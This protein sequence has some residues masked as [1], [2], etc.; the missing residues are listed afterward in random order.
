MDRT[1]DEDTIPAM[2]LPALHVFSPY[3]IST[4]KH[5]AIFLMNYYRGYNR[6]DDRLISYAANSLM[7]L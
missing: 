2:A 1:E 6:L 3:Q 5:R 4:I 7:G